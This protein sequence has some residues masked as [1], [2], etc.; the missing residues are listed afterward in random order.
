MWQKLGTSNQQKIGCLDPT[1]F[2]NASFLEIG[3]SK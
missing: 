3:G 2:T 1:Q